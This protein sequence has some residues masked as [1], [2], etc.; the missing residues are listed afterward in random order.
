MTPVSTSAPTHPTGT[1]RL[2]V[3]AVSLALASAAGLHLAVLPD[4]LEEG[5]V[6][7][8]FFLA[9]AVLQLAAAVWVSAGAGARARQV[10]IL[11]N[12]AVIAIWA[13]SRT[14]GIPI[15]PD[16]GT[17]E[18]VATLDALSFVAELVAV[19]GLALLAWRRRVPSKV[20]R[21]GPVAALTLTS[22]LVAGTAMAFTPS[23]H[24]H[25]EPGAPVHV[26]EIGH[27]SGDHHAH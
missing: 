6:I 11:G 7:G 15:G 25:D 4:H 23:E 22:F 3:A 20:W 13:V 18:P 24:H 8:A 1:R 9:C 14:V 10:I 16:A 27:T 21:L 5:L 19:G 17:P 2:V 12:L 26:H